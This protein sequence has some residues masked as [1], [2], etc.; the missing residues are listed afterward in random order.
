MLKWF[1]GFKNSIRGFDANLLLN[2]RTLWKTIFPGK[3]FQKVLWSPNFRGKQFPPFLEKVGKTF[4][5]KS[6]RI[7]A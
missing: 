5:P 6:I 7:S 1:I 2:Y 4:I 3:V